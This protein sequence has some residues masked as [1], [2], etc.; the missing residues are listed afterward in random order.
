MG[1]GT[2]RFR[3]QQVDLSGTT[4]A[5]DPVA[6]EVQMQEALRLA[7][8]APNPVRDRASVRFAVRE[9]KET[10]LQLYNTLG[11]RVATIYHGTPPAGEQRTVQLGSQQLSDLSSGVYFLR[12]RAGEQ[13]ATRRVT[14][15][16]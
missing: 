12:L 9:K 10:T 13:T 1:V 11:Q 14:V 5:H 15:V 2:H 3:L 8:P 16:R 6:V 4:H 7:P